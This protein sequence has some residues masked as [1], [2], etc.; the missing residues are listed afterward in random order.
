MD[1]A[2]SHTTLVAAI[3]K[4]HCSKFLQLLQLEVVVGKQ[5]NR[6]MFDQQKTQGLFVS[7][8]NSPCS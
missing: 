6:N 3:L 5:C 7:L 2:G 4:G 1:G 8:L